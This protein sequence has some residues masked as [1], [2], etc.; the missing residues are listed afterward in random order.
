MFEKFDLG[1]ILKQ[2]WLFFN[3]EKVILASG[4]L[5]PIVREKN[6]YNSIRSAS[7]V[8]V[9]GSNRVIFGPIVNK[10]KLRI[11]NQL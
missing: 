3:Y 5:I 6:I 1:I 2:L 7:N 11:S 4:F 8:E 10:V 9:F